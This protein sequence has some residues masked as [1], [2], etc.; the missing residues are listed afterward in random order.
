MN[1]SANIYGQLLLFAFVTGVALGLCRDLLSAVLE[2]LFP[3]IPPKQ[4][5]VPLPSSSRELSRLYIKSGIPRSIPEIILCAVFDILLSLLSAT[6]VILL[7]YQLNY[8]QVRYFAPLSVLIGFLLYRRTLGRVLYPIIGKLC[9]TVLK[10]ISRAVKAI[11]RPAT[12]AYLRVTAAILKKKQ[13]KAARRLSARRLGF[14]IKQAELFAS[15]SST[16]KSET[17]GL[18]SKSKAKK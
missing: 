12:K 4:A 18:K 2:A 1:G 14:L 5:P 10:L 16:P 15:A 9:R 7:L 3:H 17:D 11:A 6:A 13:L 8:G